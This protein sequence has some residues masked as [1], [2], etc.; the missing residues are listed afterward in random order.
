[1]E[2]AYTIIHHLIIVFRVLQKHQFFVK[3]SKCSFGQQEIEYLGHLVSQNGVSTDPSKVQCKLDWPT[4]KTV[5]RGFLGLTGYYRRFV[6]DHGKIAS[7]LTNLLKKDQFQWT[8]IAKQ[9][10]QTLKK[11]MT[12]TPVLAL[13]DFTKGVFGCG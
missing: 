13:P 6:K 11:A 7:P 8:N 1:M 10:F 2:D 4:P 12:C 5:L 3:K 9:S